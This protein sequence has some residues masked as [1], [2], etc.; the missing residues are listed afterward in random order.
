MDFIHIE[1]LELDCIVGVRPW[2]RRRPQRIVL[3]LH[4]GVDCSPAARAGRIA[5]SCDYDQ[6]ADEVQAL[7]RFR[8]YRLIE[9]ATEELAAMLLGIHPVVRRVEIRISKPGAMPG[10]ARAAAVSIRRDRA[11]LSVRAES[12]S[13]GR[14]EVLLETQEAGLY[15]LCVEPG[16]TLILDRAPG[17]RDHGWV[18]SGELRRGQA[19]LASGERLPP[20]EEGQSLLVNPGSSETRIFYCCCPARSGG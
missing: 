8:E 14:R 7:L 11:R 6:V 17:T 20:A 15:L 2:E 4:L 13:F 18:L 9:G 5:L 19:H 12:T 3:D 16:A 1:G 10:R